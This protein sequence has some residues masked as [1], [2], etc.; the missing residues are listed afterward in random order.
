MYCPDVNW[1][2]DD[3]RPNG[4]NR[5]Y[6]YLVGRFSSGSRSP[7]GRG[8]KGFIAYDVDRA[9]LVFLKE[10]WCGDAPGIH[11]ELDTYKLFKETGVKHVATA[12]AG[13]D[14]EGEAGQVTVTQDLLTGLNPRPVRRV[15]HRFVIWEIGRPLET[16]H[17]GGEL[18]LAVLQ[19][20]LG[21]DNPSCISAISRLKFILSQVMKTPGT[22]RRFCTGTSA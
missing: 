19:A 3:K 2:D 14:V 10:Y 15:H 6:Q 9:R 18:V 5:T 22:R 12:I 4:P 8:G 1:L 16:Y 13:G 17:Q 20:L 7:T 21:A 11:R